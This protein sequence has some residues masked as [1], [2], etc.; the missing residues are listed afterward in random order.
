MMHQYDNLLKMGST[1]SNSHYNT[2]I[3]LSLPESY[4]PSLKTIMAAKCTSAVLGMSSSK[5]MKAD[6]LI[7]FFIEEAQHQVINDEYTKNAES[8][9]AAHGKNPKK[10][11]F[12]QKKTSKKF[13]SS[14]TYENCNWEGH[15]KED[16][17]LKGGEKRGKDQEI[18]NI[19]RRRK[20]NPL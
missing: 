1:L 10:G 12:C 17:W 3:M 8:T 13:R 2:I 19:K 5:Q 18:K 11:K 14:M 4:H 6:D 9:L 15:S 20:Q 16:Y 7:F